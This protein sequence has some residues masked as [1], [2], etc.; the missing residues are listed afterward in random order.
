[1]AI[2]PET[3]T[4]RS[5]LLTAGAGALATSSALAVPYYARR[6]G[7]PVFSHGVQSGDVDCSSGMVWARVDRPAEVTLEYSTTESFL[8]ASRLPVEKA[9][10][11]SDNAVKA[12][13]RGLLPDQDI[14]YRF[15][16]GDPYSSHLV[17]EP[18]VGRFRTAPMRKRSVRFVW[19]GDTAGQGWGIDDVGM[20]TYS[21]ML[22][23]EP[24]FFI[25]SGD[26]VYADG[27]IPDEIPLRDGGV[28]KNR[29]VTDEKRTVARTLEEFRG[30]W[31]YNLLDEHLLSFNAQCP[32]FFQWDDHEVLNN[33]SQSSDLSGDRRY[34]EKEIGVYEAR[35]RRAFHEMTPIRYFPTEPGRIFRKV[36]YGPLLDVFFVDLRSYRSPNRGGTE[37][38]LFGWRQADWLR[39]EL[40]AS[41]AVW[42]VIACDMPLGLV[43]WDD[44]ANSLGYEGVADGLNGPPA[45]RE[46]EI[47]DLL[48]FM[49]DNA[50]HNVVWLTADVHYTAA[51]HYDPSRAKF[52][53][54]NPFWEFVS[55]PLHSGTY[56]PKPLDMTFGPEVRFIKASKGGIDSNL[57]PS[58]GLQFFGLVDINGASEEMTV[59]LMDREDREL[60]NVTLPPVR[61]A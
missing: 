52:Q 48:S 3:L 8:N 25:H 58:V 33:W 40:S 7:A 32:T 1:M 4:R 39:R 47:A 20:K 56:G 18:V 36:A 5:F 35:A 30:Q 49:R 16:A 12:M 23:H 50:I 19:S 10:I 38:G 53:E 42:K 6:H 41:Q 11:A 15:T 17:S 59:R 55:G 14:F 31:K 13:L 45:A 2:V 24:D 21:T 57:P 43:I 54:F 28:W 22:R 60:W 27:P 34:P 44:Y 26:T 61:A 51:H 46:R 9:T 37:N 29:I